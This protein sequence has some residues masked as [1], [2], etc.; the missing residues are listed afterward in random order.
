[1]FTFKSIIY[2]LHFLTVAEIFLL[3]IPP[4][5][6]QV[7]ES[8]LKHNLQFFI[9]RYG[10]PVC[11]VKG[12]YSPDHKKVV[13]PCGERIIHRSESTYRRHLHASQVTNSPSFGI[14][15]GTKLFE[16]LVIP[17]DLPF[18]PMHL[19]Y[20][21]VNKS[22][23]SA[24]CKYKLVEVETLSCLI[25][26]VKVP[27]YFRRQP[28]RLLTEMQLWKAQE[29][30]IFLLYL[31]PLIVSCLIQST[32]EHSGT[33]FLLYYLLSSAVYLMYKED[34]CEQDLHDATACI[35]NTLA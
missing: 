31:A 7:I 25:D 9:F 15:G 3:I 6:I 14:K 24:I 8:M 20:L 27:H 23:L 2:D 29:H 21:G 33:V 28:R 26:H 35:A 5:N 19:L 22:F 30:R 4:S 16:L 34:I 32:R 18:D 11:L 17:T 10:C 13:F 12:E 1:M